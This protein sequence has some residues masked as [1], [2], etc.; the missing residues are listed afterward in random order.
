MDII[1]D[2]VVCNNEM[3]WIGIWIGLGRKYIVIL[4]EYVHRWLIP[5]YGFF[6]GFR[7]KERRH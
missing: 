2:F 4:N 5:F 1:D 3:A 7:E 6:I